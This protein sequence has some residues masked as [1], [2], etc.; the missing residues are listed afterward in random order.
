MRAGTGC[1][2][3][4]PVGYMAR[5]HR[6]AKQLSRHRHYHHRY[7]QVRLNCWNSMIPG[8]EVAKPRP[9]AQTDLD[10]QQI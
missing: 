1:Q 7:R 6:L 8:D 10:V 5:Y 3:G 4:D 2:E 9:F